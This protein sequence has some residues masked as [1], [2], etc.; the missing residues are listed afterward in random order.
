MAL[1]SKLP[2]VGTTI[3]TVMSKL[4]SECGAI[5]LSQGFPDFPVD[6][7]LIALVDKA[8]RAL[9][10][11]LGPYELQDRTGLQI[12][13]ANRKRQLAAGS[14]PGRYV[15]IADRLCEMGRQGRGSPMKKGW[16]D[17]SSGAGQPDPEIE[18]MVAAW[19]AEHAT[20]GQSFSTDEI[21]MRIMAAIV[22]E[23]NLILEEGIATSDTAVDIVWTEG[24]G[25]PKHLGGPMFW[26]EETGIERMREA[27][28][29]IEAQSPGSWKA[30]KIF[31]G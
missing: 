11:P 5:N 20:G 2:H 31:Q 16:Y 22:N 27:F 1:T 17:H 28:A 13:W 30:A 7:K 26:A 23:A 29:A 25:F 12:S 18:A 14:W 21:V 6:E 19:R 24:Y 15:D 10:M 4:A 3:F 9:G 8:M